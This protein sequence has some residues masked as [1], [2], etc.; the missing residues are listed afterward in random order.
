MMIDRDAWINTFYNTDVFTKEGLP[1]ETLW[2]GQ[3]PTGSPNWIDPRKPEF[4]DGGKYFQYNPGEAKKLMDFLEQPWTDDVL[5]YTETASRR[6]IFTP[7]ATQVIQPIYQTSMGQW[8]RYE[9]Q[10]AP[11]LPVLEAWVQKFGY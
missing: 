11:V 1:A 7:S 4:G 10:L 8:R 5:K 3:L 6:A 2:N 9:A